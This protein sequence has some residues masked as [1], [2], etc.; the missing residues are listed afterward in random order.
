MLGFL[1][2][3]FRIL[4]KQFGILFLFL[5]ALLLLSIIMQDGDTAVNLMSMF[6]LFVALLP[7]SSI[8]IEEQENMLPWLVSLPNGRKR[9]VAAKYILLLSFPLITGILCGILL[10]ILTGSIAFLQ[11]AL[12]FAAIGI[13]IQAIQMPLYYKIGYQKG[14]FIF[15]VLCGAMGG[16]AGFM[17]GIEID[18]PFI[19]TGI[20]SIFVLITLAA[21]FVSLLI[22]QTIVN[23]KEY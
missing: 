8:A 20:I 9:M 6:P 7:L 1:W 13:L 12:L 4:Y 18:I 14:K 5:P 10:A 19:N 23:K 16:F 21:I 2:K 3:E 15:M 17:S 22:S 11:M